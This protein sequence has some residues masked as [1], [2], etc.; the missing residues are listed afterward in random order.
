[1]NVSLLKKLAAEAGV[2]IYCEA[3]QPVYANSRLLAVHTAQGGIQKIT[4]PRRYSKVTEVFSSQTVTIDAS[5]FEYAF[6]T[7]DTALF[8]ISP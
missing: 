7:P 4:L 2:N 5:D 8:E 3:E 1:M 6:K